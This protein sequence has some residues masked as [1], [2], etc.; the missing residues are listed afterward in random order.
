MGGT[1]RQIRYWRRVFYV[2]PGG[3]AGGVWPQSGRSSYRYQRQQYALSGG[4]IGSSIGRVF[5][6]F[7]LILRRLRHARVT[8]WLN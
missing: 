5:V 4:F 8:G 7:P 1:R 3:G 6:A 2:W